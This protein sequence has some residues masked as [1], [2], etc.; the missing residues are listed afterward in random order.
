M[1]KILIAFF[2]IGLFGCTTLKDGTCCD[3]KTQCTKQTECCDKTK[4]EGH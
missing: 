1:K 2:M 4:S 3:K